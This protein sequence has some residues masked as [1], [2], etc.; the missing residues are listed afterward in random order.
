MARTTTSAR[1]VPWSVRTSRSAIAGPAVRSWIVPPSRST[2]TARPRARRAGCTVAACGVK[3]APRMPGTSTIAAACLGVEQVPVVA[4]AEP[5]V[6]L[7][8]LPDPPHL[9]VV[10]G[11][12]DGAALV[13][14][15]VDAGARRPRRR[16]RRRCGASP[17]PCARPRPA[18]RPAPPR[19]R[20]RR[21]RRRT[22]RRC[23][24][25]PRTRRFPL[26][27]DDPQ[28]R[29][30]AQQ[31]VRGP[32]PGEPGADDGHVGVAV[33]GQRGPRRR[34]RRRAPASRAS[35]RSAPRP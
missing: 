34:G 29:V 21:S 26:E 2:S 9:G 11:E 8:V 30:G 14:P 4:E 6:V 13:E 25:T 32:Q 35:T 12:V 16:P 24:P 22:N 1:T 23:A 15:A 20:A 10:D 3:V 19:R 28:R 33:A 31:R 17:A 18:R 5:L 27:H 7:A